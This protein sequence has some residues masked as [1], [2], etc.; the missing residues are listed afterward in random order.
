MSAYS[1]FVQSKTNSAF[2]EIFFW[3]GIIFVLYGLGKLGFKSLLNKP[4]KIKNMVITPQKDA[5]KTCDY[6]GQTQYA[7]FNTC[8]RC[9]KDFRKPY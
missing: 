5:M 8:V 3:I 2:L 4:K 1:K 7:S 6:C 9:G